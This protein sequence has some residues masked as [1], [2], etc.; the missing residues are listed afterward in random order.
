MSGVLGY[1][2]SGVSKTSEAFPRILNSPDVPRA[3]IRAMACNS[4][5]LMVAWRAA[6][7]SEPGRGVARH[8]VGSVISA[9]L[10]VSRLAQSNS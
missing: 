10:H 6:L 1:K 7:S 9:R 2:T 5:A 4:I 8:H 3:R